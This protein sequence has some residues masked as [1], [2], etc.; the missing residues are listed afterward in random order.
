[1]NRRD[2]STLLLASGTGASLFFANGAAAAQG[3]PVEGRDYTRIEPPQTPSVQGK[4]E[5]LEFFTYAC[6]HC[7]A[8]EPIIAPWAKSLPADVV[9]R[10]VPVNFLFNV[11]NFQRTYYALETTGLVDTMQAKVFAAVHVDKQRLDKPEDIAALI[12]K[13]GG[14][15][16]K[17]LAAFKSFSVATS[18]AR[19]KKLQADYKIDAVPALTIQGRFLT[20]PSQAGGGPQ[21]LAVAD[22]LIDRVRKG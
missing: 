4:I 12:A 14:D 21:S 16:A 8:F 22:A 15:P 1:M 10:R 2:F 18:V 3:V 11:E 7:S 17:F 5:V 19:A 6:P 9:F 20:S 13:N